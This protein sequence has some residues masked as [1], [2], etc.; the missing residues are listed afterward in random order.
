MYTLLTLHTKMI[1]ELLN[2]EMAIGIKLYIISKEI[3][4]VNPNENQPWVF[5]GKIDVET[6]APIIRPPDVN[7]RLIG[8]D[9]D[10]GKHWRQEENGATEDEM[11]GW[12]HRLHGHEFEQTLGDSEGQRSLACCSSWGHKKSG[13]T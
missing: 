9:L 4:P 7:S 2:L 10:A 5:I 3:K 11:V 12:H 6:E 1:S 8:K 13:M